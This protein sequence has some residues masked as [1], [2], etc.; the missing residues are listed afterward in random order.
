MF[1]V[2]AMRDELRDLRNELNQST[3]QKDALIVQL[4]QTLVLLT[5]QQYQRM[6]KPT[7]L[8]GQDGFLLQ[9]IQSLSTI[10]NDLSNNVHTVK[11]PLP[12]INNLQQ[13]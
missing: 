10:N 1:L 8:S 12:S 7:E 2:D 3:R 5:Q 11:Q 6:L 4:Q 9:N 13:F